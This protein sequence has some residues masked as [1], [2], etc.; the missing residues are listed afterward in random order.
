MQRN[1]GNRKL[2]YV[3]DK[4]I[5]T[6]LFRNFA[7]APDKYHRNSQ[8][9]NFW[10]VLTPE[11]AQ[12]LIDEGLN[13]REKLNRDGDTEYRLQVF[14]NYGNFPPTVIKI[15]GKVQTKLDEDTIADLDRDELEKVDL[16]ISPYRWTFEDRDGVK[17][18]LDKGY[19][20]IVEDR[21]SQMYEEDLREEE[22][23]FKDF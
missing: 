4:D 21:L 13:V 2:V 23:P 3:E 10:V 16:A 7:G 19:F 15:C 11:K 6:I 14:V 18:Y 20:T 17:A 5:V 1:S 12:E 9:P 8:M 22:L